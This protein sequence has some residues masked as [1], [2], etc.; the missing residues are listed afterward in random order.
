[1]YFWSQINQSTN[2]MRCIILFSLLTLFMFSCDTSENVKHEGVETLTQD[3][4]KASGETQGTTYS[5]TYQDPNNR[6]LKP[7]I[8]SLLAA[9][10]LELSTYVPSSIISEL[11]KSEEHSFSLE[12]YS[13][14]TN[15]IDCY[16]KSKEIYYNTNGTFNPALYPVIDY[17]GFYDGNQ[18]EKISL[19]E[20]DKLLSFTS[21]GESEFSLKG[22]VLSKKH[23]ESKLDFNAIAQ[24]H[25]VDVVGDFLK[26]KGIENYMVEIGGEVKCQGLNP[27][28]NEWTV[29]IEKPIENAEPGSTDYQFIAKL[30]NMSL[31]TSGNYR[32]FYMIDGKKYAHTI[33]PVTGY[34]VNHNLLS[35]TVIAKSCTQADGYA[36]SFMV[37][38]LINSIDFINNNPDLELEAYFVFDNNGT[39]DFTVTK[40]FDKYIK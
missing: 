29:G 7:S 31:A 2:K 12:K 34:P 27:D 23:L 30:K 28:G 6:N 16:N 9:Y 24:G 39:L 40:G 20:I 15:F 3:Y 14:S 19:E 36:T 38:G 21:F 11:N 13:N 5:I 10:D 37:M 18:L 8:D 32:K 1:M 25:S 26:S 17:W 35:V 4:L 33:N 22:K